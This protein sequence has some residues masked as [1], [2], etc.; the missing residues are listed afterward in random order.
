MFYVSRASV[1]SA[2]R[3][4][5]ISPGGASA[6]VWKQDSDAGDGSARHAWTDKVCKKSV[7]S[8]KECKRR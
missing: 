2:I 7:W 5:E 3:R 1:S 8:G 4:V 6:P